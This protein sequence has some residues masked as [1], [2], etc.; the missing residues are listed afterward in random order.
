M[1][2]ILKEDVKS[3]GRAGDVVDVSQGYARN[4]LIPRGI[5]V[6]ADKKNIEAVERERE[7]IQRKIMKEKEGAQ[8]LAQRLSGIN[9]TIRAKAGEEGKLFGS[10]TSK[11]ISE[12]LKKEGF[13]IDKKRIYLEEPI[14]RV[15][16][17]TVDIKL[18]HDVAA[19]LSINII[20]E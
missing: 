2:V 12:V 10:I 8:E 1:K 20:E 16:N 11:D 17:Y 15:G 6:I 4:Y 18:S 9:L 3:L 5:A 7:A 19:K 13:D 14:K